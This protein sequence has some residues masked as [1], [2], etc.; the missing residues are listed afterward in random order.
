MLLTFTAGLIEKQGN[1]SDKESS[2][3]V[4]MDKYTRP[5]VNPES[6]NQVFSFA[7]SYLA[8]LFVKIL[9]KTSENI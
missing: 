4:W 6:N 8:K 3:L 1:E 2:I 5:R 9:D 7:E